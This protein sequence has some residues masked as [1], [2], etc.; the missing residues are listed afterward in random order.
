MKAQTSRTVREMIRYVYFALQKPT[1]IITYLS[2]HAASSFVPRPL[3]EEKGP[4]THRQRMH[5]IHV[6]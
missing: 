3:E 6:V 5:Q 4:G 2:S 1:A